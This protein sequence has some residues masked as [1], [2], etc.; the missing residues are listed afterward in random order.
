MARK[1]VK[2]W[3]DHRI[4]GIG[5][6]EAR[7]AF[8]KDS[9]KKISL[10]GEW[11]FK[12]V[13]APELSPEGFEQSGACEGWDK[14][15]VPS[16]WQLRGYDKMHYTD[17]LYPFPVNPP[18]VPDENPTGIYKKTVVLDEQWME[19][20]TVLKFHGVDSAF[21]VW[22]NGKHVGFGKVSRLPSE[23]DITG[24][25]K[26]GENDITVRVYKWS[27]GTYL[28]DQ[29]MWWL[30][31]IYR[32]V[33][34]INEEKNA[35]L[36]LRVNGTLDDSYKNGFFTAGI[37]MKQ[38]GTNLGW[39]L[40]YKGKTVLEGELVSEG[41]DICI[42]AEIPE[43]HTWTAETP[44]L[45]EFT[46]MTEN[47]E[48][49]VRCGFRKIEIKDKNFRVNNQVILLNGVNHHDYNP[50]EGRRVTREQMESDIRLMKQYNINAVR[51][52]HYP[53]NEYFYDL[54]D[55]YGLYV[56]NE[57]DLECHGFEWVENYTWITDDETW[58]DAYVDRSVRMVKRD[59]NH[60]SIIM[61][62]MGNES[63]FGCNFRSAA[64]AI[65]E[66]DDTRL[67]H[68]E[69]DRDASIADVYSTMYTRHKAL[70]NLGRDT[71]KKKPHVVCEYAHAM[72]NGPGGLKEY[73]EIFERYPR[74]QGGFIWEWVDHG[75]KKYD[76]NGKAYYTYGG[77]YGDYPNSGAFCC[78]GLI[79]AD[80]RPTP[81][82]LQVKKVMEPVKFIDFDKTTGEITVCNKYD[83]T[84]LS[85]LEGTFK[86]HTLQGILLEGEVDLSEIAPHGC[87]RITVYDS[88]ESGAWCDE[89]D[90][91]LTIKVCYKEKQIW[92]EEAH[93]EV[94]F[95]QECLNKA[96]RETVK[97]PADNGSS[98]ELHMVEKS[99]IIYVEGRNF[100][101]EFDRVHGYL[102]GY[103]LNGERLICK[104]LGLN[105]WRAPVDND[106][107]VA[108]IWEKAMLK[109]MTNLVEKVTV[110]EK[111]Q[112]VVISVSQ[113]YAP[114]T[115]DWKIIVKAEY[116]IQADGLISMSYHGVPT[117]VQL[118]ESFP[119]I[120]MRFVLDKACEQA[121]WYGRGPLETYPDC[122]EGNAIGCWE[123]NVDDFYF[124]YVLPQETG[125]H[126]DTRWA[127]FVTEA[128]N[129]ICIASDKE[130]SFGALHYTQEDLTQATHTNELHKT[131]NIQ[132]SVDYAQHG[133]GSA[134]W[135]A[136]CLEKD[137]LYPEPFTFTWKIFGTGKE[138]L[139]ER[140]EQYRRK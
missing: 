86:I 48:V 58:K 114:I 131:E 130:F 12:Y 51:C 36:D 71:A 30:S 91:W 84:D 52:S 137:K 108:E 109:A 70:E 6:R 50:R 32:D 41:K 100:T 60:P 89:Q 19:K 16:V 28:E 75:I 106:K 65:R 24:F 45:Y 7:T 68:Y 74:L 9:Q 63:A 61:W 99:G 1:K 4:T 57:A 73:W 88:A 135:G 116:H 118:P 124:P 21:D 62:S 93:H 15:D 20:D 128:G 29:D 87:K 104:G 133:L 98:G 8:Y 102:S 25:V 43:V 139:V 115:V 110:E 5:R 11:D 77:D 126:E 42:E 47:Q 56:I 140:A 113:I 90:I 97:E 69:E 76:S 136:E 122:K 101:A 49:T 27:D 35:V 18:H 94:A 123:K 111:E 96:A 138:S 14:I 67:V 80:R 107:N 39:K 40:S 59:R 64:E 10:N 119:R 134:S 85:H 120:G 79:Q 3:E 81:G 83:F 38:A 22:V 72:G 37:T 2:R 31:G 78:D 127:A 125:N 66:L 95:H 82:I 132:L 121:V 53:A 34:L 46:V 103:T 54:C 44:E 23:F 117:G 105:F 33:E 92:S 55:E 17:V 129:G 112:E 13:D 26:T